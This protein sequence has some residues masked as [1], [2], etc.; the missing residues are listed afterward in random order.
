VN[1]RTT[2]P[3]DIDILADLAAM[4]AAP[5]SGAA[6]RWIRMPEIVRLTGL[7]PRTIYRRIREG[8][9]PP[10]KRI[11]HRVAVWLASDVRDW[12]EK[13][14]AEWERQVRTGKYKQP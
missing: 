13:Q 2:R 1:D 14:L 10:G 4:P 12:Q 9:F 3:E 7:S 5:I 11:S 8:S 6:E